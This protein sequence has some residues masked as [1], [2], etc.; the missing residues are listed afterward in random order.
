MLDPF[1][2]CQESRSGRA[3]F[4]RAAVFWL[5][6]VAVMAL[7]TP[8]QAGSALFDFNNAPQFAPLPLDLTVDGITAQFS[9][10]GQG[11]SIQD[12]AQVI[13]VLPAGFTGLGIVPS[14]VFP[15][16]LLVSFPQTVLTNF[17][18]MF[19]PQDLNTDSSATMRVSAFMNGV[20]VGTNTAIS[21]Y[22]GVWPSGT[23]SFSSAQ[24]FNSVTIHYDKPPP[25]GGDY[26]PIFAAD[27]MTVTAQVPEPATFTL[28]LAGLAGI[29]IATRRLAQKAFV[30]R[31]DPFR[32]HAS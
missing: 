2:K 23:L 4:Y 30:P 18:I 31:V 20:L 11:F 24:G 28:M 13:G 14:S 27:N 26:G 32:K 17:S 1:R 15:A 19:A 25:L 8:A 9:A 16:D 7:C 29:G 21:D 5:F 10:T 6:G 12:T 3:T 22:Q